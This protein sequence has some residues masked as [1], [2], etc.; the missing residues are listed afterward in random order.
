[1]KCF[2]CGNG[3]LDR[4][5]VKVPH[6]I[7]GCK[8]DVEDTV[9][10]CNKCG[11]ISIP[12]DRVKEHGR[13]VDETYRRLEGILS[14]EEIRAARER[15]NMS[16]REFAEYL[17]VGEASVKRWERGVLPDKS[18]SDLIRLKTDPETA[19]Q[20]WLRL[21]A[22]AGKRAARAATGKKKAVRRAA[23]PAASRSGRAGAARGKG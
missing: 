7:R 5:R 10:V 18:S 12:W 22:L 16:Q 17:G 4:K 2:D 9:L 15:L 1:M 6:E 8:F 23:P 13:L 20:N 21:K 11:A 3:R 14:A 19:H